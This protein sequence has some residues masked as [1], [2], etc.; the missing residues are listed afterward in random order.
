M[1]SSVSCELD[2]SVTAG[3]CVPEKMT[4]AGVEPACPLASVCWSTEASVG[5]SGVAGGGAAGLGVTTKVPDAPV[6]MPGRSRAAAGQ[7]LGEAPVHH[8]H[9]TKLAHHDVLRL[10]V[11]VDDALRVRKGDRV[12]NLLEDGQQGVQGIPGQHRRVPRLQPA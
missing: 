1:P 10:E 8:E 7:N 3:F 4:G 2:K 5:T 6:A 11:P 12:A 9:F